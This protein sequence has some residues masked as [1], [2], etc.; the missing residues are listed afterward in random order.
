MKVSL[1]DDNF[2]CSK[3]K[4]NEMTGPMLE[5]TSVAKTNENRFRC[6]TP[7][8]LSYEFTGGQTQSVVFSPTTSNLKP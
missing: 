4:N 6:I 1:S 8:M 5:A 2:Q 7:R 3:Q